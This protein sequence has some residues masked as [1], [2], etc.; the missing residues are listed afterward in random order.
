MDI[1]VKIIQFIKSNNMDYTL[2]VTIFVAVLGWIVAIVLQH[3]NIRNQH[4]VQ[5]RYDIY[6]QL[7]QAKK[8]I[9]DLNCTP[10]S[11]HG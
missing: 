8:D 2:V 11:R 3:R 10:F 1:F 5:I 4:K 6:K 7:V 9:Q